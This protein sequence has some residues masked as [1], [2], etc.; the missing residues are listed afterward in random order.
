MTFYYLFVDTIINVT[1][2]I[3]ITIPATM[4]V[5]RASP[6]NSVPTRMAVIGSN[7]PKTEALVAPILRVASANDAVDGGHYG[8]KYSQS[9]KIEPRH[10]MVET[11]THIDACD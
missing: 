1:A 4:F 2:A 11:Y 6:R 5:V 3:E 8:W 7:T 9:H 10:T